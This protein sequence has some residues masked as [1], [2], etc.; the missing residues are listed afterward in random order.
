MIDINPLLKYGWTEF[1]TIAKSDSE[2]IDI[3]S[4]IGI[5]S[6]DLNGIIINK[7]KPKKEGEGMK[8]SLSFKFGLSSFPYHTDTAYLDKP[9]DY[10]LFYN[11]TL[12]KT[13]TNLISMDVFWEQLS[14]EELKIFEKSIFL[15]KTPHFQK[16]VHLISGIEKNIRFDPNIMFP[17]NSYSKI[18]QTKINE[19]LKNQKPISIDWNQHKILI[20]D[21]RKILHNRAK[22]QESNRILKRIYINE[23]EKK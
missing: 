3:A 21:N 20:L 12:N 23:L 22:V 16:F 5:V 18:A 13:C 6:K 7:I 15:L 19:Y 8:D 17:Y 4:S 1:N 10:I 9:V 14:N 11:E 2:L